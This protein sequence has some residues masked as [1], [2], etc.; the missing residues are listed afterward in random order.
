MEDKKPLS[1]LYPEAT[2]GPLKDPG[3]IAPPSK[4]RRFFRA[5]DYQ[6]VTLIAFAAC[7][8]I[9]FG[10]LG[11][12]IFHVV[13]ERSQQV[14]SREIAV[15]V[16]QKL[17]ELNSTD[18]YATMETNVDEG[19]KNCTVGHPQI[20]LTHHYLEA[21]KPPRTETTTIDLRQDITSA[22]LWW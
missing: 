12:V 21:G 22:S 3:I 5:R 1:S 7:G 16:A 9:L 2:R 14:S 20:L 6:P 15:A 10:V 19:L 8:A 17:T 11:T 4:R 18:T 13:R